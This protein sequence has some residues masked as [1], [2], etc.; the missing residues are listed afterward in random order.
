LG[1]CTAK[2]QVGF[3]LCAFWDDLLRRHPHLIIDNCAS[4]GRRMDLET[5]SCSVPLWRTDFP[6]D[7]LA[8]Q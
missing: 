1:D 2:R 3:A 4:G 5:M 8:K 7:P 6:G